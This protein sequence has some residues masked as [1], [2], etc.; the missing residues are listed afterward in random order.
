[1][2][3]ASKKFDKRGIP[4]FLLLQNIDCIDCGY[5]LE[6]PRR[7]GSNVYQE[8][9]LSKKEKYQTFLAENFQ[10]L[11]LKKWAGFR[12]AWKNSIPVPSY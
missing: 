4:I 7:G 3:L 12:D 5:S 2:L 10:F 11:K 1:M 6:P 9:V 8:S